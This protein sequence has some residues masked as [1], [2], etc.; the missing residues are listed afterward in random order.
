MRRDASGAF[1]SLRLDAAGYRAASFLDERLFAEPFDQGLSTP[2]SLDEAAAGIGLRPHFIFH[3]GHVG[4][5]LMSRLLGEHAQVFALREP[6]LLRSLLE[7]PPASPPLPT[8]LAL[9]GRTW[10]PGERAIVK[11]TSLV[12]A[13]AERILADASARE[14]A[15]PTRALFMFVDAFT[16]LRGILAG[17]NSQRETRQLAPSRRRRLMRQAPALVTADE[18]MAVEPRTLGEL[19]AMNWLTEMLSLAGAAQVAGRRGYWLHFDRFL[20]DPLGGF[21]AVCRHFELD[22]D[23]RSLRPI[24]AGPLMSRYSKAPQFEYDAALRREVLQSAETLHRE[25]LHRGLDWLGRV[26]AGDSG[27]ARLLAAHARP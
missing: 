7:P 8:V 24:L 16:Y 23:P 15:N 19:A 21:A 14:A 11:A 2:R 9:L 22:S 18:V 12:N 25:E 17:E 4:S 20:V 13:L 1:T 3:V 26:A 5:T 10:H 6:L 27:I